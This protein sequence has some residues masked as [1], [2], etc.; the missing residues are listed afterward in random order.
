MTSIR[1]PLN[2]RSPSWILAHFHVGRLPIDPWLTLDLAPNRLLEAGGRDRGNFH[3]SGQPSHLLQ[4]PPPHPLTS[5][6]KTHLF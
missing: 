4:A 2:L 3:L 1:S 6:T 5:V